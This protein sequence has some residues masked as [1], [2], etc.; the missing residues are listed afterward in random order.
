MTTTATT[1]TNSVSNPWRPSMPIVF[2]G[3][4]LAVSVGTHYAPG[5]LDAVTLSTWIDTAS[6][7]PLLVYML[8]ALGLGVLVAATVLRAHGG[9]ASRLAPLGELAQMLGLL[10]TMLAF[11]AVL[12]DMGQAQPALAP[13]MKS[14]A[15]AIVTT[16]LGLSIST[17]TLAIRL[18][19]ARS[20]EG[21]G[22]SDPEAT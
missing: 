17:L 2:G 13:M 1:L 21:E 22:T 12:A 5:L 16:V 14:I 18:A 9:V 3:C 6:L 11:P 7:G 10:G 8:L 19:D 4:A 20:S 15:F